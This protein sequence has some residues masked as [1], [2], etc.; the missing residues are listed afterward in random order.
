MILI[1]LHREI[2]LRISLPHFGKFRLWFLR[3]I[4][5]AGTQSHN[6][7]LVWKWTGIYY[8]QCLQRM[9]EAVTASELQ[10]I[11]ILARDTTPLKMQGVVMSVAKL[12]ADLTPQFHH[13]YMQVLWTFHLRCVDKSLIK[14]TL[15]SF[16]VDPNNSTPIINPD[17]FVRCVTRYFW[18]P[19]PAQLFKTMPP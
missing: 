3:G 11:Y 16:T 15:C 13:S 5:P 19:G 4:F 10:N 1:S 9:L 7:F 12:F 14:I 8:Y 6:S 18:Y 2:F 17:E